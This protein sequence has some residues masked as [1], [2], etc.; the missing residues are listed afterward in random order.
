VTDNSSFRAPAGRVLVLAFGVL[1]LAACSQADGLPLH[2][3]FDLGAEDLQDMVNT[4]PVEIRDAI[5]ANPTGFLERVK[6]VLELSS[7]LLL[8]ADKEHDLGEGYSPADLVELDDY[9][10]SRSRAGMQLR[11]VALPDALAMAAAAENEGIKLVFSSAYRSYAYQKTVYTRNVRELGREQADRESAQ[12]GKSQHQLGTTIDFG[13]ITD[14]FAETPGG[15]WLYANAWKYGYSLSYPR[16]HESLTGYRH[17]IWHYRYI[18]RPAARMEREF[19]DSVQYYLLVFLADH[20]EQLRGA[21][22]TG[23]DN[24]T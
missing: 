1:L 4:L 22:T 19:F 14:E 9:R 2:P 16:G 17:E 24:S 8:L 13:S 15:K 11:A 7:D 12:P 5:S 6:D 20:L 10:I 21:Y 18:S 23:N 3:S